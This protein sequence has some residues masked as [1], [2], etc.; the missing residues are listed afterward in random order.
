[1]SERYHRT[2]VLLEPEQHQ[3]LLALAQSQNTSISA[4]L[5]RILEHYL[6]EQ[7]LEKQLEALKQLTALRKKIRERSGVYLGDLIA[8]AKEEKENH[9]ERI[10]RNEE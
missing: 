3:E 5:R 2:Q 7:Q 6:N 1:M 4:V 9:I 8:Q 10:L